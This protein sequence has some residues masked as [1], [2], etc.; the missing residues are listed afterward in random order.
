LKNATDTEFPQLK[1][2]S[3]SP[4]DAMAVTRF[5]ITRALPMIM[6]SL[7]LYYNILVKLIPY[8]KYV[9]HYKSE[10]T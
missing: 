6:P 9:L 10:H 4:K 7:V 2:V 1:N 3:L 5:N 8:E